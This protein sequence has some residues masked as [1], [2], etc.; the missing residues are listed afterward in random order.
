M[1]EMI[2]K[3]DLGD[4]IRAKARVFFQ[5]EQSRMAR[6]AQQNRTGDPDSFRSGNY[7]YREGQQTIQSILRDENPR[8]V[9]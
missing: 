5:K 8:E 7:S 9:T 1:V 4:A 3:L 2:D 6:E